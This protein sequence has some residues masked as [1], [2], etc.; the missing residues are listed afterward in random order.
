MGITVGL[1]SSIVIW[2]F[3]RNTPEEC[4]MK[5]DSILRISRSKNNQVDVLKE[6]NW[7][8]SEAKRT[9]TFW[10]YNIGLSMYSLVATAIS[11]H[12][13][14]I[15]HLAGLSREQA[16]LVFYHPH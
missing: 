7:E 15:F 14:S 9:Y 3:A 4:G 2:I 6:E 16:I 10:I 12:I 13:T 1:V 11:F 8:L 5:T